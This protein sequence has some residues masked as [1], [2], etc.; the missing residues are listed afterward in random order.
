MCEYSEIEI[1]ELSNGKT[2]KQVNEEV[3]REVE[4]IYQEGWAKGLLF[5]SK[6][7]R[8]T[9]IWLTLMEVKTCW[10]LTARKEAIK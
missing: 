10:S 7:K 6:T 5:P 4:C 8:V 1:I 3:R 2:I 9:S